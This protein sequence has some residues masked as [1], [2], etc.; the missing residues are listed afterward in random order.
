MPSIGRSAAATATAEHRERLFCRS[1]DEHSASV[2]LLL[3]FPMTDA[4]R[5]SHLSA[6]HLRPAAKKKWVKLSASQAGGEG[7]LVVRGCWKG[8]A[9][10]L[11]LGVEERVGERRR[12]AQQTRAAWDWISAPSP[13][14]LS[15]SCVAGEGRRE[16]LRREIGIK[17]RLTSPLDDCRPGQRSHPQSASR[18]DQR[19]SRPACVRSVQQFLHARTQT[20]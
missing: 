5:S 18:S 17:L 8:N 15:R 2:R 7:F 1:D 13:Q 6:L 20:C 19:K 9:P 16:Q 11:P 14:P 3:V 10:S 4:P 12:A